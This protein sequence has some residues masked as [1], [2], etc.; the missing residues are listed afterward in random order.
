[1]SNEQSNSPVAADPF[2]DAKPMPA[3]ARANG[4]VQR[5]SLI[6]S[7]AEHY[8]MDAGAFFDTIT[9]TLM[10]QNTSKEAVAAFLVVANKY[11]LNPFTRE[12][13]AFP[14][15][16]S[17][18]IRPI[19][20]IDGWAK[21]VNDQESCD[22]FELLDLFT[23]EGAF[24]G[25]EARFHRKDRQHAVV[26]REYLE[27]CNKGTE[28]WKKWPR[29]MTRHKA[30]IQGARLAFGF[31]G[32]EDEDEAERVIEAQAT[33]VHRPM[34]TMKAITTMDLSATKPAEPRDPP[35]GQAMQ[36]TSAS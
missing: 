27:E 7:M 3:T 25:V 15:S 12:I 35:G 11:G 16:K 26:V 29:R 31:S 6:A 22:G 30:Y 17:G 21:L 1:M 20:S 33:T 10:P 14:D 9:R 18:G 19:V 5:R 28:P 4:S 24:I 8:G 23:E 34:Q 13:Y 36:E 2:P 32:I